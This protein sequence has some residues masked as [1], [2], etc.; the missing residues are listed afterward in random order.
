VDLR[1]LIGLNELENEYLK[2]H[3]L[4]YN[5]KYFN[6]YLIYPVPDKNL[7]GL[8]VHTSFD[9]DG[10][11]RFGPNVIDTDTLNY[12][13]VE[14]SF[15]EMIDA[16]EKTFKFI[17]KDYLSFDYCGIRPKIKLNGSLYLDFWIKNPTD[18]NISGYFEFCGIESPGFTSA[19]SIAQE[20]V[21]SLKNL[22]LV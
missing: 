18:T 11:V 15:E 20:F 3:Y 8:G 14:E 1:T 4:K 2:A 7:K 6:D 10:I 5:K 16:I 9:M 17:D 21:E 19:P 13:P 12:S 22:N